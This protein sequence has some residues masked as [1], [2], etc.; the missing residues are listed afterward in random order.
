M[1]PAIVETSSRIAVGL[2]VILL[3]VAIASGADQRIV[4]VL[5]R[6]LEAA[7]LA[8]TLAEVIFR[9]LRLRLA[10]RK[11]WAIGKRDRKDIVRLVERPGRFWFWTAVEGV[12]LLGATAVAAFW[13]WL[14]MQGWNSN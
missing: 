9:S 5:L 14:L 6:I 2:L 12:L 13:V 1:R 7:L 11:G 4:T 3:V 8:L 10:F